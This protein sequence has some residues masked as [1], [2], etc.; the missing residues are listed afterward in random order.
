VPDPAELLAVARMLAEG[1]TETPPSDAQ[2]RRAVSSAYYALFHTVVRAGAQR[3]MGPG[4]EGRP[5]YNLL[6][7]GFT[8]SRLKDVCNRLDVTQL[9]PRMQ[10]QLGRQ[11]VGQDIR[12]FAS[13]FVALQELRELAD[14][15]S[16]ALLGQS[17]AIGSVETADLALQAF[18]RITPDEQA[19]VLALMLVTSR[20]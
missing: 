9:A 15:D 7:R 14:Y 16:R 8:H 2:L 11:S 10:E 12:D 3:F 18:A 13:S 6:Y 17:D 5:G 20:A 4:S 1:S 19:D